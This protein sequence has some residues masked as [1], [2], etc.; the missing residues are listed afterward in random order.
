MIRRTLQVATWALAIALVALPVVAVV[1]GWIG[2][3]RWPRS[4]RSAA[5]A[6]AA[7]T[8]CATAM[9]ASGCWK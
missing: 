3:E 1:N 2:A 5:A 6:G 4:R 9:A 7:W 8:S